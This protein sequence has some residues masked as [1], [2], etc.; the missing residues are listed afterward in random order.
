M[1]MKEDFE[2]GMTY[3]NWPHGNATMKVIAK[4]DDLERIQVELMNSKGNMVKRWTD[5]RRNYHNA[6]DST[7]YVLVDVE[8]F[9]MPCFNA[10]DV[11]EVDA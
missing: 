8:K 6:T 5:I 9:Y 3:K 2:V 11:V 10:T 7:T 4:N 1:A